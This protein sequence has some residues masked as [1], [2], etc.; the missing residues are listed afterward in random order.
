MLLNEFYEDVYFAIMEQ[1][2]KNMNAFEENWGTN[3][4]R[5]KNARYVPI[6]LRVSH[7]AFEKNMNCKYFTL[8]FQVFEKSNFFFTKKMHSLRNKNWKDN[9]F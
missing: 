2:E 9:R 5:I 7:L 8:N 1:D 3:I 4:F 6:S